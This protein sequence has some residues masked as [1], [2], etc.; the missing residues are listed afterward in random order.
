M[1]ITAAEGGWEKVRLLFAQNEEGILKET[2]LTS[3]A[4]GLRQIL[5]EI[6]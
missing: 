5:L 2:Q 6:E 3:G 1:E 4:V